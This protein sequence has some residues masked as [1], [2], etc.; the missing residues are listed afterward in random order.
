MA[1]PSGLWLVFG[2]FLLDWSSSSLLSFTFSALMHTFNADLI[3]FEDL[4]PN[5]QKQNFV[6]AFNAGDSLGVERAI[7]VDQLVGT[8]FSE[9]KQLMLSYLTSAFNHLSK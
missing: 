4:S 2:C 8:D 1:W 7:E 9:N 6:I 5:D 3:P